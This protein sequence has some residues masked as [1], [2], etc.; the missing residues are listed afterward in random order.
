MLIRKTKPPLL[1]W[2]KQTLSSSVHSRWRGPRPPTRNR[3]VP[4]PRLELD[5]SSRRP[6]PRRG[7]APTSP[8]PRRRFPRPVTCFPTP[9]GTPPKKYFPKNKI[10]PPRL[11]SLN[12]RPPPPPSSPHRAHKPK[13]RRT[14]AE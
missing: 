10:E 11:A 1:Q 12:A 5:P 4:R 3:R 14:E 6:S 13:S 2:T 7:A 9:R 8:N